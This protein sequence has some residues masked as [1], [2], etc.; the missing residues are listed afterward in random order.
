VV[1]AESLTHRESRAAAEDE[2]A[3]ARAKL[4]AAEATAAAFEAQGR[5]EAEVVARLREAGNELDAKLREQQATIDSL[6]AEVETLRQA[7]DEER[8]SW[9]LQLEEAVAGARDAG[10]AQARKEVE[11][12]RAKD[13]HREAETRQEAEAQ[14]RATAFAEGLAKGRAEDKIFRRHVTKELEAAVQEVRRAIAEAKPVPPAPDTLVTA[15]GPN[16]TA[17]GVSGW[18]GSFLKS[19]SSPLERMHPEIGGRVPD[20]L[21]NAAPLRHSVHRTSKDLALKE[22]KGKNAAKAADV[23]VFDTKQGVADAELRS[24]HAAATQAAAEEAA[25]RKHAEHRAGVLAKRLQSVETSLSEAQAAATQ[26][27]AR[28]KEL[29]QQVTSLNASLEEGQARAVEL[30]S[31][32]EELDALL[33]QRADSAAALNE[34]EARVAHHMMTVELAQEEVADMR[35]ELRAAK[36]R[37]ERAEAAAA[38]A[39]ARAE[40]SEARAEMATHSAAEARKLVTELEAQR[41]KAVATASEMEERAAA[42]NAIAS[43]ERSTAADLAQRAESSMPEFYK[44]ELRLAR[45]RI[46]AVTAAQAAAEAALAPATAEAERARQALQDAERRAEEAEAR[47]NKAE[48]EAAAHAREAAVLAEAASSA[49]GAASTAMSTATEG[50]EAAFFLSELE[51]MERLIEDIAVAAANQTTHDPSVDLTQ[52]AT[53]D[54]HSIGEDASG[55][56]TPIWLRSAGSAL[57]AMP[58]RL[59]LSDGQGTAAALVTDREA[60]A[61]PSEDGRIESQWWEAERASLHATLAESE[62][63]LQSMEAQLNAALELARKATKEGAAS[64]QLDSMGLSAAGLGKHNAQLA[65]ARS[66]PRQRSAITAASED[67]DDDTFSFGSL[68]TAEIEE[69]AE[70]VVGVSNSSSTAG[71]ATSLAEMES[72]AEAV[73]KALRRRGVVGERSDVGSDAPRSAWRSAL[74]RVTESERESRDSSPSAWVAAAWQKSVGALTAVL[75]PRPPPPVG[76]L[77]VD[78]RSPDELLAEV[79][80]IDFRAQA[81]REE[82]QLEALASDGMA[83]ARELEQRQHA[84]RS[85]IDAL[86]VGRASADAQAAATRRALQLELDERSLECDRLH[87]KNRELEAELEDHGA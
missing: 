81:R 45:E 7:M 38:E 66:L 20:T 32:C 49:R 75:A 72:M 77:L 8:G 24:Q 29:E 42:A 82:A 47:A 39:A 58:R 26:L 15:V 1:T 73:E 17:N 69:R 3:R 36:E 56:G 35:E 76:T 59:D 6:Q 34:A 46:A 62:S 51:T 30:N 70:R 31:R 57:R 11:A 27:A 80:A 61:A 50:P 65:E 52:A 60:A 87:R 12:Q 40:A 44:S 28:E 83:A 5:A 85:V 74:A 71:L 22:P 55:G 4:A 64:Q 84:V 43:A 19:A 18:I 53:G 48:A 86:V 67:R 2:A 21:R 79:T 16:A 37:M 10:A 25:G 23:K 33:Q 78:G 54:R 13:A 9:A 41:D 14:A 63:A 68:S